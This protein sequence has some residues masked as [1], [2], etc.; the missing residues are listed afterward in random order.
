MTFND[1]EQEFFSGLEKGAPRRNGIR[2]AIDAALEKQDAEGALMLYHEFIDEDTFN[3]DNLQAT[4]IF[5]EY[6]AY[7]EAHEELQEKY[8]NDV[9]WCFKWVL[10]N[11]Y[12]FYQIPMEQIERI[13][14]Q[15][16]DF[17]KKYHY[18]LRTYYQFLCLFLRDFIVPGGSFLGVTA[19]EAFSRMLRAGRDDL[20]D[21]KACELNFEFKYYLLVEDNPEKALEIIKPVFSGQLHCSE[22]PD[23]T[24]SSLGRYY[25]EHGDLKNALK[26]ATKSYRVFHG[27]NNRHLGSLAAPFS[28]NFRI[29]SYHEPG[30]AV[31]MM[32]ELL[33]LMA[34]NQNAVDC[35]DF[36]L[37]S[38]DTLMN[39]EK[40]GYQHIHLNLPFKDEPIYSSQGIYP[41]GVLKDFMYE[42]A[43]F[44]ADKLDTRNGSRIFTDQLERTFD[45]GR[46]TIRRQTKP[47]IPVLEYID[48][49]LDNGSLPPDFSLPRKKPEKGQPEFADGALDG[50]TFFH[51]R[52][53]EVQLGELE[54][55]I[56]LAGS[57]KSRLA[58]SK[59]EKYLQSSQV[60]ALPL[61]DTVQNFIMEHTEELNPNDIYDYGVVLIV[62]SK[63]YEA[64]KLGLIIMELFSDYNDRLLEAIMKLSAC[65]E[66]TLF[67]IWAVRRLENGN[68]LIFRMAKHTSGWG[69]IFAVD[70]LEAD[71]D[72][73]RDWMLHNGIHNSIHPGYLANTCFDHAGVREL[74]KGEPDIHEMQDI[75]YILY[76]L[77][78]EGPCIGIDAYEDADEIIDSFL[79]NTERFSEEDADDENFFKLVSLIR[80]YRD[81]P[82]QDD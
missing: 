35:F 5:P 67:C 77:I 62:S 57:G 51:M 46:I 75:A 14:V 49:Y 76:F 41:I 16:A 21:C 56:R 40:A 65:D 61:A 32:K 33:P 13:F 6:L 73:I 28:V 53:E 18:S 39:L 15:Y 69:K 66:F 59:T 31:K 42:K 19:R 25:F 64:V 58:V 36:F 30:K 34:S 7:F 11:F 24:Y 50:I 20:S 9:M 3:C 68:D 23:V 43:K 52:P 45:F 1:Y 71:T 10:A 55:L 17:C 2:R 81:E 48:E 26:Y 79:E 80:E 54:D 8:K 12:E 70:N 37:A 82:E 47:D 63:N 74:L 4:L 22:V 38:Y 78:E 44:Y 72:E 29:I 27:K 60:R